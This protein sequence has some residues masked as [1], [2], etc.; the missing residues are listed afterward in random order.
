MYMYIYIIRGIISPGE[1]FN[2]CRGCV[3]GNVPERRVSDAAG[4]FE[5]T[6]A[7]RAAYLARLVHL[8]RRLPQRPPGSSQLPAQYTLNRPCSDDIIRSRLTIFDAD[9]S[10]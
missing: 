6:R 3:P 4:G 9:V 2:R 1:L 7:P 10:P 8:L 5:A